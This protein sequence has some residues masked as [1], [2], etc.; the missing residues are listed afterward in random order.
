MLITIRLTQTGYGAILGESLFQS[1]NDSLS[2]DMDRSDSWTER[3]DDVV[4]NGWQTATAG[5]YAVIIQ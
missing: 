3:S 2:A 5:L 1:I 4:V